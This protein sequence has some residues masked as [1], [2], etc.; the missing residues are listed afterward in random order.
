MS[1]IEGR[2]NGL[3]IQMPTSNVNVTISPLTP[4]HLP[5]DNDDAGNT[6]IPAACKFIRLS[7][8]P[9]KVRLQLGLKPYSST[10]LMIFPWNSSRTLW[11]GTLATKI[12]IY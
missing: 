4:A 7:L 5:L 1:A 2:H 9:S 3:D 10:R 11:D 6:T 12:S 8:E